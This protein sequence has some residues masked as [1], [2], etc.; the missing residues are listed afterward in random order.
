[1]LVVDEWAEVGAAGSTKE[2]QQI[3]ATLRR[4]VSLGRAVGCTALLATQRPTGDT[5]D[6]GTR[7]L[8]AHRFALRCGDRYQADAILG[9]G[10][11]DPRSFS[12]LLLVV[13]FGVTV[14]L[15]R[16]CSSSMSQMGRSPA[17]CTRS[18]SPA[19][20]VA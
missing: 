9:V 16:A 11:Y 10:T 20:R 6:V 7:S 14:D 12:V 18:S 19:A 4:V 17:L 13:P 5:I 3:D 2:R 1:M 15:P 8:L